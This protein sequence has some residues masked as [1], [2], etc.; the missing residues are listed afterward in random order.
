MDH[1]QLWNKLATKGSVICMTI[2][3]HSLRKFQASWILTWGYAW[4]LRSG[5]MP[6][7]APQTPFCSKKSLFRCCNLG[8]YLHY[9]VM[10]VISGN[11]LLFPCATGVRM[12]TQEHMLL[13]R[14]QP[15]LLSAREPYMV[16][17]LSAHGVVRPQDHDCIGRLESAMPT[18]DLRRVTQYQANP[19]PLVLLFDWFRVSEI[20]LSWWSNIGVPTPLN[21]FIQSR[22]SNS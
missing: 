14:D 13:G 1:M 20:A 11:Q 19:D 18:K 22:R 8:K 16:I 17:V 5:W 21:D 9:S 15:I 6:V 4:V 10:A 12:S 7:T 3:W 2:T